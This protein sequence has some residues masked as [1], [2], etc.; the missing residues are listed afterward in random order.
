MGE[1]GRVFCFHL[2]PF[3]SET[4]DT[5]A[6]SLLARRSSQG[7]VMR[8]CPTSGAVENVCLGGQGWV[9]R[10]SFLPRDLSVSQEGQGGENV[11]STGQNFLLSF[12]QGAESSVPWV[13]EAFHARCQRERGCQF[14]VPG[15]TYPPQKITKCPPPP[16]MEK[17][18]LS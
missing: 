18:S 4:P 17:P 9:D 1:A 7:F 13:P 16:G 8:S 14:G 2:S 11:K 5:Q 10:F 12:N 3:P 15:G 6:N